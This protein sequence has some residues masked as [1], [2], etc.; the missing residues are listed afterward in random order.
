MVEKFAGRR[1]VF[2][3]LLKEIPG[4]KVNEPMGA[5]YLFPDISYYFGK[6]KGAI[7]INNSL[8]F[9]EHLLQD[10]HVATVAGTPFGAPECIRFS[11]CLLYTSPSPR[12]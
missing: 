11:Y 12:D 9:S 5:F 8:D 2:I 4:F 7:T 10:A 3:K 6:S 1:K